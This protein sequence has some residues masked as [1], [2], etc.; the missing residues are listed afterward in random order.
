MLGAT[1]E[2]FNQALPGYQENLTAKTQALMAWLSGH[3]VD[4]SK[5]G[6][7]KVLNSGMAMG[8]V[9]TVIGSLAGQPCLFSCF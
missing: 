6:I 7:G 8:F 1:V 3:G 9:N 5:T 4:V 2:Q